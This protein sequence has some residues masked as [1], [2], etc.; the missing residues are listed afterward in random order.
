MNGHSSGAIIAA[1]VLL[2]L[3]LVGVLAIVLGL[4]RV[5]FGGCA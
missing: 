1:V 5:I 3:A 4:V 2:S